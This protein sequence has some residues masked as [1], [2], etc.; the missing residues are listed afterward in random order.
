MGAFSL[1]SMYLALHNV[2][3]TFFLSLAQL[4]HTHGSHISGWH[5]CA[6]SV[7]NNVHYIK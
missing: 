7:C 6:Y 2:T 1:L 5:A 4:E 3:S